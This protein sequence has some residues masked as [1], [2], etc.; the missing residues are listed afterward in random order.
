MKI[1]KISEGEI[2]KKSKKLTNNSGTFIKKSKRNRAVF[3]FEQKRWQTIGKVYE[4]LIAIL[5]IAS[6]IGFFRTEGAL[7][8]L[9][10]V[11]M[12]GLFS[13]AERTRLLP[14]KFFLK[15]VK[16][17]PHTIEFEYS[18]SKKVQFTFPTDEVHFAIYSYEKKIELAY[19]N[20]RMIF[21]NAAEMSIFLDKVISIVKLDFYKS[22][23]LGM[24][25]EVLKYKVL[26]NNN[27]K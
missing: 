19:S 9:C 16:I 14:K 25:K 3:N 11:T 4:G 20:H 17:T 6:F 1:I 26:T 18:N 15:S 22:V 12:F 8:F 2:V 5:I 10:G 13:I 27:S 21:T 7:S 24:N 23:E